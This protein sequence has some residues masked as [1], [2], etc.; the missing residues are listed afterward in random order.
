[1]YYYYSYRFKYGKYNIVEKDESIVG[2]YEDEFEKNIDYKEK[3][4]ELIKKTYM[5][6]EEY[7]NGNRKKFSVKISPEG[8]EFQKKVW[9]DLIKIP[10]GETRT[11]KD[12]AKNIENE[13][14]YRAVG[15][16]NN[17]NP[18]LIIIPCHR[19]IGSSGDMTG[20]RLGIDMKKD[21]LEM[22]NKNK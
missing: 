2:I 7:L 20:Y 19:V 1:M 4:T 10:Y 18:I 21:L 14:A 16:A 3:E 9:E 8:T 11:Y 15:N 5:E 12:I 6:I 22:E 17:K 13:K